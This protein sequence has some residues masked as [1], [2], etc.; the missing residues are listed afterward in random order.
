MAN[1]WCYLNSDGKLIKMAFLWKIGG[2]SNLEI[3]VRLANLGL[4]ISKQTLHKI[5]N[6]L[7]GKRKGHSF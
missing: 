7:R 6:H 2:V 4:R 1:A 3:L 5:L